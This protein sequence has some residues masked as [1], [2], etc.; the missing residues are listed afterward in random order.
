MINFRVSLAISF[1]VILGISP[2]VIAVVPSSSLLIA[3]ATPK[4][5]PA[6]PVRLIPRRAINPT[7]TRPQPKPETAKPTSE[8]LGLTGPTDGRGSA[9]VEVQALQAVD[10]DSVG[11]IDDKDGGLGME[12]WGMAERSLVTRLVSMLPRNVSSPSMRN[13]LR[14]LLLTRAMAPTRTGPGP[15]LLSLRIA[16]LFDLGDLES[17]MQLLSR[18]PL[19]SIDEELLFTEVEIRFFRQDNAGACGKVQAAAQEF[20]DSYWLQAAAYCLALADKKAEATLLSDILAER[21][22]SV[23]PAFFAAMDRLSGAPPPAIHSLLGPSALYLSML[24]T[25]GISLPMDV[26]QKATAAVNKAIALSP[27]A[28]IDLRL[29]A[30][31][32]AAKRGILSSK[33][34]NDIYGAVPFEASKLD[35]LLPQAE[36]E[37]GGRS[38]ALMV[39]AAALQADPMAR[40]KVLQA[41]FKL[42]QSK[43]GLR[44]FAIASRPMLMELAVIPDL[45]WFAGNAARALIMVGE[46]DRARQWI[47]LDLEQAGKKTGEKPPPGDLWPLAILIDAQGAGDLTSDNFESWWQHRNAQDEK[48][49]IGSARGFLGLLDALDVAL[50]A[51]LWVPLLGPPVLR[52]S[53]ILVY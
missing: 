1:A 45:S 26:T 28:A 36:A 30:G 24:R 16:A 43:G 22:A 50:P 19:A 27:N 23:H 51:K 17:A 4:I 25:A 46:F 52:L 32:R 48:G 29:A 49:A 39:R 53:P 33:V 5:S 6:G 40:A 18:S 37:W 38:R 44:V 14:R 2:P 20:K 34:L 21:S 42:A 3:Q 9:P 15:S 7:I 41:A 35:R 47:E 8:S 13:L 31:E 10:S 11:V 12:M